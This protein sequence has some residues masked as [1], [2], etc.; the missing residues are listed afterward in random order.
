MLSNIKELSANDGCLNTDSDT[1]I[2][3]NDDD[4]YSGDDN[5]G[6]LTKREL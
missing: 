1:N 6:H 2:N 3:I 4:H 5:D